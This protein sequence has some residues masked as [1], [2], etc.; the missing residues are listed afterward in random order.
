MLEKIH[1]SFSL[2]TSLTLSGGFCQSKSSSLVVFRGLRFLKI[3][4][5]FKSIDLN[6]LLRF[7]PD[8]IELELPY[9]E[10]DSKI[11]LKSSV[12]VRSVVLSADIGKLDLFINFINNL[13]NLFQSKS[14]FTN[15]L[16]NDISPVDLAFYLKSLRIHFD[17]EL[18]F[19]IHSKCLLILLL[20][21]DKE[22]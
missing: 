21:E 16:G 9:L 5:R 18:Q 15:E 12:N 4:S 19:Q 7:M 3:D 8:L 13:P 2:L 17:N 10:R 11:I 20:K 1:P 22:L 6:Q 14:K